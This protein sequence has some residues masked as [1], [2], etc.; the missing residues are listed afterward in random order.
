MK[1][2][3]L[4]TV[5]LAG[6]LVWNGSA[7]AHHSTAYYFDTSKEITLEGEITRVEWVNP[8]ILLFIQSKNGRGEPEAWILEGLGPNVAT[9]SGLEKERLQQ[10]TLISARAHPPRDGLIL[11]DKL[12]VL[13]EATESPSKSLRIAEGGEIRFPNGDVRVFGRGPGFKS[14]H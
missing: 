9:G 10:G 8:H 6:V 3:G 7:V 11:N 12:T 1:F 13:R 5:V 14:L 4:G 2:A